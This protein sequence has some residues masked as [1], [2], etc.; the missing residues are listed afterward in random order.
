VLFGATAAVGLL[1]ER[2]VTTGFLVIAGTMIITPLMIKLGDSL[3]AR[4]TKT[5]GLAPG[6]YAEGLSGHLVIVGLDEVG[7][8][9][10]L[11][12]E[13][14]AVPYIAFDRDY[15]AVTRGKRT[16]RNVHLGDI[17]ARPVQEAAGLSR[18]RAVFI[19]TTDM[20]MHQHYPSLD[21][22]AQVD[23]IRRQTELRAK[24]I[25]HAGTGFIESTL[26][27][28]GSLLKGMGVA[29]DQVAT[30]VDSLRKDDCALIQQ[31]LSA[32]A[33]DTAAS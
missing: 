32:T 24:G 16:G 26:F 13:H 5:P 31:A 2:G 21:I 19:S 4:F 3:A 33:E 22:Y 28:G 8:V 9:I 12:A 20:D 29:E 1:S 18:A 14:A 23:T 6:S 15:R 30:L 7:Y 27:R 11:M 17:Y 10:A 25:K